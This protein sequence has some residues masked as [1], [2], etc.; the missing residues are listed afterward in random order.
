MTK[1]F[2]KDKARINGISLDIPFGRGN[3]LI[4]VYYRLSA[5]LGKVTLCSITPLIGKY[6]AF[7][8]PNY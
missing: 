6:T 2:I 5:T 7:L 4:S 3:E 1:L 8:P